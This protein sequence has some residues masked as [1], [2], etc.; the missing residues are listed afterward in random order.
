MA[1]T[2][3]Q[4]ISFTNDHLRP[5]A[6]AM[7]TVLSTAENIVNEWNSG[8]GDLFPNSNE[9]V[10]DGASVNGKDS[11]GGDGRRVLTGA[12]VTNLIT[13]AIEISNYKKNGTLSDG[14]DNLF[15]WNTI[16]KTKVNGKPLF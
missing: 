5:F 7:Y 14:T 1:V 9:I 15:F 12:D 2:D 8:I 10:L 11:V 13:R 6:D 16:I 3:P 4:A